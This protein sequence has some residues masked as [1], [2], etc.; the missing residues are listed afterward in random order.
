MLFTKRS[1]LFWLYL[2][3]V[4]N[5]SP[6]TKCSLLAIEKRYEEKNRMKQ[7]V[8][9]Y[10]ICILMQT[11]SCILRKQQHILSS[12][13]IA[14]HIM[15]KWVWVEYN[16]AM[17]GFAHMHRWRR[18]YY[19]NNYELV[20][21]TNVKRTKCEPNGGKFFNV[22][23]NVGAKPKGRRAK[24]LKLPVWNV[25]HHGLLFSILFSLHLWNALEMTRTI[26]ISF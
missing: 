15:E 4:L 23:E 11:S 1:F 12:T 3:R 19:I 5:C 26:L 20:R 8:L 25:L 2:A 18:L 16:A 21:R 9:W 24:E 13:N 6:V 14:I 7:T 10:Q 22:N 17:Y